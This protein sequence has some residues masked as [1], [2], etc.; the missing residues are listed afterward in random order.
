MGQEQVFRPSPSGR[1]DP[2]RLR[3]DQES[4]SGCLGRTRGSELQ[5]M[6]VHSWCSRAPVAPGEGEREIGRGQCG[7]GLLRSLK[8]PVCVSKSVSA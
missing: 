8:R 2:Q 5:R 6:Q 1:T 4:V 7:R 3:T